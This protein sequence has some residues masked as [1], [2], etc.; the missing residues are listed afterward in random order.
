[1]AIINDPRSTA[2]D[3][4]RIIQV[5]PPLTAKV[6]KLANSAFYAPRNKITAVQQ[7]IIWVGYDAVRELALSQKVCQLFLKDEEIFGY[8]RIAL[9]RHSL[10]V[11]L[12]GKLIYR[13]EFG[14]RGDTVY[15][16]GL[17]HDMGLIAEDQFYPDEFRTVLEKTTQDTRTLNRI[18]TEV[19]G[20]DH[21]EV[22]RFILNDWQ[23]P[24]EIETAVGLHHRPHKA[25]DHTARM[26]HTI[27]V[28]DQFCQSR[29]MGYTRAAQDDPE[30]LQKS[31]DH[32][33]IQ[34]HALEFLFED[35][36]R[37][38]TLMEEQGFFES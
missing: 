28:A 29:D 24:R 9:W 25:L 1:V 31:L 38:I 5:D 26:A 33:N 17:L 10:A 11:A 32:L 8:S 23:I 34:H 20:F 15:V 14:Q 36:H 3:L 30:R 2:K 21:A 6:L 27:Y 22:G 7:A 4:Q 35:V 13:R 19:F 16:A 12:L 18:E 37:E